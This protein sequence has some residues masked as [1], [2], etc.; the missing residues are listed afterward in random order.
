MITNNQ[1]ADSWTAELGLDWQEGNFQIY[2]Q[3]ILYQK[4]DSYLYYLYK[5]MF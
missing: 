3:D 4:A 5:Y 2:P 1:K